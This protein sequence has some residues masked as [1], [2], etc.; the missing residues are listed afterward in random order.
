MMQ[1][2]LPLLQIWVLLCG[3]LWTLPSLGQQRQGMQRVAYE[4]VVD[5]AT[6]KNLKSR[7]VS[8]YAVLGDIKSMS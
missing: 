2:E 6:I 8:L 1:T 3:K 5:K 7:L 4:L